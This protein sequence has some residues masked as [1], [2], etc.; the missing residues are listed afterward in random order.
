MSKK[1]QGINLSHLGQA[2]MTEYVKLRHMEYCKLFEISYPRS[3]IKEVKL[4][5]GELSNNI[6]TLVQN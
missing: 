6:Y 5:Y 1:E 3:K 2:P 4:N